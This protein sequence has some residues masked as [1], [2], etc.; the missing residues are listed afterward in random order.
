MNKVVGFEEVRHLFR[1]G[2]T[3]MAGGFMGCGAPD[4][5]LEFV[6]SLGLRDIT[7]ISSDTARPLTYS[8]RLIASGS[9]GKLIASHIGTNP[10]TGR[11][12]TEGALS[13]DLVP[14][15]SLAER[16]RAGGCGLGGVLTPTGLGTS[17]EVGKTKLMVDG[18]EYLLETPLR[19]D[20][21]LV[22]GSIVDRFGNVR[23]LGTTRNFNPLMA[24]A[25]VSVIVEADRLVEVGEIG[26]EDVMTPGILVDYVVRRGGAA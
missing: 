4:S 21:A 20:V 19:A 23:Y 14:Q 2:M 8:G 12:M 17:V 1:D 26:P 25:A 11:L 13:V 7:L 3:I 24:M 9:V 18:R 6:A 22:G 16:I 10:D 15:G 5:L